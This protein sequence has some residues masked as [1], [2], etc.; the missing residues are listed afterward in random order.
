MSEYLPDNFEVTDEGDAGEAADIE[1][2]DDTET[3]DTV[4]SSMM[5]YYTIVNGDLI[6][7]SIAFK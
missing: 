7:V 1:E 5:E 6:K 3:N 4:N 2:L